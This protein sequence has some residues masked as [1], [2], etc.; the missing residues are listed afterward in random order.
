MVNVFIAENSDL[1][2]LFTLL[3]GMFTQN[4]GCIELQIWVECNTSFYQFINWEQHKAND[5]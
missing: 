2:L 1:Y 5:A 3:C 4:P